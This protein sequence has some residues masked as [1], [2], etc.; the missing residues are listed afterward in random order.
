M[1]LRPEEGMVLR[2]EEGLVA[3]QMRRGSSSDTR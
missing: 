2:P 3:D 1:V